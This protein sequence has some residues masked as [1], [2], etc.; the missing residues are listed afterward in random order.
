VIREIVSSATR[1]SAAHA[2]HAQTELRRLRR[3][4][5]AALADFECLIV[6]SAPLFP[7]IAEVLADPLR[8]NTE[9]GR[10]TN[11]VNLLDLCALAIPAGLRPDGLPFGITLIAK[12]DRDGWLAGLGRRLHAS[13][14]RTL[15][16]TGQPLPPLEPAR[17][18][19]NQVAKLAVVG[20][21]LSGQPLNRELTELGGKLLA[22]GRTKPDYA[23]YALSTTPPKPGLVRVAAGSG[24]A[25]EL[26]VWELSFEAL[27]RFIQNVR[28]PL[29][30]G[31]VELESGEQV[32][33]FLCEAIAAEGA[34]NITA[35][36]GWR[37]YRASMN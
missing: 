19:G 3:V 8:I 2:Q 13:L 14:A 4:C 21:H 32:H 6:P 11:F 26:E 15:G 33:G 28:G 27:G 35:F 18:A 24:K 10:Y 30:I 34:A 20:A 5:H 22:P 31:T 9:L 16:A 37:A 36:G 23:L 7:R 17:T 12:H 1:Y 29:C 25:I